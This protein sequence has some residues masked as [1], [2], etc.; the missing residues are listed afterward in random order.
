MFFKLMAGMR[1]PAHVKVVGVDDWAW[2][3]GINY[4]TV[5]IDGGAVMQEQVA[6]VRHIAGQGYTHRSS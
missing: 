5:M 2:K 4:G 1:L 6:L 3:K